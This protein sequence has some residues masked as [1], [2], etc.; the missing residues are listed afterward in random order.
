MRLRSV[1]AAGV[2]AVGTIAFI[3]PL[4]ASAAPAFHVPFPCNQVWHGNSSNSSAHESYELDFN[5]G[6]TPTADLGDTVVAAAGGT[7]R[8]ASHQGS[9]NGYGNLVKIEHSDSY[10]TYYAHLNTIAVTVG[11][12]VSRGQSIGTLGNTSKP[13]NNITPHL[14]FEVRQG[15]T[16]YPGNIRRAVFN[17]STFAYPDANVTSRNCST[18]YDPAA[19]CGSGYKVIDTARLGTAGAVDLLWNGTRNCVV[20]LKFTSLGT[21]TAT[22]AYLE[23]AGA[24]RVTDS[25]SYGHY[26]GPVS[27]VSPNCIRWG[28]ATGGVAYNSPSEHC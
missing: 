16:G 6:S 10:F 4:S 5:R 24:T 25:G 27:A 19:V 12:V 26:A 22:S 20:T 3:P 2:L 15:A 18:N 14:H 1:L 21:P 9:A 23:P 28:G 13:G 11:Q 17:G 8:T 7:V